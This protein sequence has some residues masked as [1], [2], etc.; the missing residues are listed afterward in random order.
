MNWS[1]DH[2]AW[3][4]SLELPN[5]DDQW[6]LELKLRRLAT[7][8]SEL[9]ELDERIEVRSQCEDIEEAVRS[10]MAFRG[11]RT[12]IATNVVA[13]L[14]DPRRFKDHASVASYVGLV[15]SEHS[16]GNRVH[17]G[18]ITKTGSRHLRRLL[19]EAS[20]SYRRLYPES[21]EIRQRR[22]RA[23]R[24]ARDLARSVE[25]RLVKKYRRLS[26]AKHTNL[27]KA[28][29]AREL[30]GHLWQAMRMVG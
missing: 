9:Q 27:A 10:L 11:V 16:S 23:P 5:S 12:L 22:D 8:E 1:R 19:I 14:G 2:R 17:R 28:A 29:V 26:M 3:L 13:E 30:I 7:R 4:R 24:A 20:R 15:S 6:L 21:K 25:R 18:A